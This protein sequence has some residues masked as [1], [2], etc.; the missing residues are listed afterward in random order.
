M[1]LYK[2]VC[3]RLASLFQL[4][5]LSIA[6]EELK[7]MN[8]DLSSDLSDMEAKNK[9]IIPSENNESEIAD[10]R[11]QISILAEEKIELH[12]KNQ[13]LVIFIF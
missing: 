6:Y 1:L 7:Q 3:I 12:Q 10:I 4:R 13:R 9:Q 2:H 5:E 8:A 11:G